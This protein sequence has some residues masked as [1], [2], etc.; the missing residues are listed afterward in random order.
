MGAWQELR[1]RVPAPEAEVLEALLTEA[2]ALGFNLEDAQ[3]QP[4]YE[5]APG[6]TPL[7][8]E[9]V[10][11]AYFPA[12]LDLTRVLLEL[13]SL[14]I[15]P[16]QLRHLAAQDWANL[17][18]QDW[19]ALNFGP[20][21]WVCPVGESVP[22]P[23]AIVV[24]LDPGM[25]FGTG[26]H[27]TTAL[28]LEW[29]A[30]QDLQGQ[31]VIDYGCGSGILA[32]AALKLGAVQAIAVDYDPQALRATAQ[33]ATQNG[34]ATRLQIYLPQDLPA[35]AQADLTLA[36]ILANPLVELAPLLQRHTRPQRPLILAGLL[37]HQADE[38]SA[39]YRPPCVLRQQAQRGD[40]LR[41]DFTTAG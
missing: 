24:A 39:A 10:L 18:K 36:N 32:I 15:A 29:L 7:W 21:L 5:P 12:D 1:L 14:G 2:G 40:W 13:A 23:N 9:I 34:V 20:R 17:W 38:V 33:N 30:T 4:I 37:A 6:E 3:D 16:V 31:T 35:T 27:P 25:A 8:P 11:Q 22:D 41:L 19:Q 26:T 28:C